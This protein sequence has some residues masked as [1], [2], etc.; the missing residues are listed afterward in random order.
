MSEKNQADAGGLRARHWCC[1]M[2]TSFTK[3]NKILWT[4]TTQSY[5]KHSTKHQI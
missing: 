4:T 3:H 1:M 5:T 2:M